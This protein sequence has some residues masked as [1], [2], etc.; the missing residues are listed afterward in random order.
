MSSN[1]SISQMLAQLE[2]KIAHH[3]ERQ[4]FHA[5]Q[6]TFHREQ[7]ALHAAELATSIERF[8]A[9]SAAAAA[10][11]ELLDRSRPGSP[12][13]PARDDNEDLGKGR[14]LSRMIARVLEDKRPNEVFGPS[15]VTAEINRRWGAKLRRRPDPRSVAATLRRWA[16]A[17]RI[18]RTREGRAHYESLYV[19]RKPAP[20][21]GS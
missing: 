7:A 18:H 21:A 10:A 20:A 8:E 1:L 13:P 12:P 16:V 11:G 5:Q 17:G 14:P 19:K 2:T 6:E 9:F 4:A 3:R 15:A